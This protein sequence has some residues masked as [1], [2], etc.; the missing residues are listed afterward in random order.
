MVS[1]PRTEAE[2]LTFVGL[3]VAL[4]VS[5]LFVSTDFGIVRALASG[6][7]FGLI[8]AI[9]IALLVVLWRGVP[10]LLFPDGEETTHRK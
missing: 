9:G 6:T 7:F 2:W 4:Y 8:M 1:A 5:F 3:S 10:D